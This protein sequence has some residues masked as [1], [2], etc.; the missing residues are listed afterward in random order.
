MTFFLDFDRTLFDTYSSYHYLSKKL[1]VVPEVKVLFDEVM[2]GKEKFNLDNPQRADVAAA[3]ERIFTDGTI[4]LEPGEYAEYVYPDAQTFLDAHGAHS[5][6]VTANRACPSYQQAKL[7][8]SGLFAI[9]QE[10]RNIPF[11]KGDTKGK[12]VAELVNKYDG[13]HVFVDDHDTQ[14]DAV[15]AYCP[16]VRAYEM[17]RDGKEGSGRHRTI[18]SFAEVETNV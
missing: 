12:E 6:I 4:S 8:A 16:E 2:L 5:V 13:P 10:V 7:E 14:L 15:A 18:Q 1:E 3:M 17:R 11:G 9:V